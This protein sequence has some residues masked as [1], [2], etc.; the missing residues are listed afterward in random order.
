MKINMEKIKNSDIIELR[1]EVSKIDEELGSQMHEPSWAR[2]KELLEY[3]GILL[4]EIY[5]RKGG[6]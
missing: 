6:H 3:K 5:F 2:T 1:Q 4:K